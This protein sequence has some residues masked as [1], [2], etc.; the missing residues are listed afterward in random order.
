MESV[1]SFN[2]QFCKEKIY[3]FKSFI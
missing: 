2:T 3:V 1:G